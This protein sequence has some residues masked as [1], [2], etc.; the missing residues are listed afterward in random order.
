MF[1]VNNIVNNIVIVNFEHISHLVL[2]FLSLT[3]SRYMPAGE[4]LLGQQRHLNL[5]KGAT[6]QYYLKLSH[7]FP[8]HPFSPFSGG[9]ER[10]IG[11][12]WVNQKDIVNYEYITR[13]LNMNKFFS[14]QD[15]S[16]FLQFFRNDMVTF[17]IFSLQYHAGSFSLFSTSL[18]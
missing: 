16:F 4:I 10:A 2:V 5:F 14:P 8:V 18:Y 17:C 7:L 1:K 9:R 11:S 15:V 12:E 13:I 3:L 6:T